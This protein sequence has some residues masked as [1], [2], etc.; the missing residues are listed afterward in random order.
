MPLGHE[1]GAE[2]SDDQSP[3]A[4]VDPELSTG[5]LMENIYVYFLT[6]SDPKPL[7]CKCSVQ[8]FTFHTC[9]L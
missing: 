2:A 3:G 1:G 7:C 9:I 6:C 8:D 4:P 5:L